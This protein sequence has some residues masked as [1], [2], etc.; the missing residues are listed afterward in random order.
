VWYC[1]PASAALSFEVAM[2]DALPHLFAEEPG[3]L[4]AGDS[5]EEPGWKNRVGWWSWLSPLLQRYT[6]ALHPHAAGWFYMLL[7]L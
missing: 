1:V 3:L 6:A 5:R 2:R 4:G 7:S